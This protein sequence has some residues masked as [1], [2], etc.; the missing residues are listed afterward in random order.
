MLHGEGLASYNVVEFFVDTYEDKMEDHY[1]GENGEDLM[2]STSDEHRGPGRRRNDR[3][4]L[5]Q[6][7][8]PKFM[9]KLRI[10]RS[11]GHNQLP[12]FIG[13]FFP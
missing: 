13:R 8:H 4:F 11:E 5:Y 6:P 3:R 12:N 7:N 9:K 1:L 10:K 2:R